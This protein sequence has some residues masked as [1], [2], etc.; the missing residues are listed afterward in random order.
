LVRVGV[1]LL[2]A[3]CNDPKIKTAFWGFL[4]SAT[5]TWVKCLL[6]GALIHDEQKGMVLITL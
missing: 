3:L 5:M 6:L 2:I 4:A 1:H